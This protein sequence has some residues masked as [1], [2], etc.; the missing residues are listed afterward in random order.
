MLG[1]RKPLALL[2]LRLEIRHIDVPTNENLIELAEYSYNDE[3]D[4]GGNVK[5]T[6]SR[7]VRDFVRD[8]RGSGG[9]A[10]VSFE[11]RD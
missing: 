8:Y 10:V 1:A 9:R 3:F 11:F 2:P 5:K 6:G 4:A 7:R